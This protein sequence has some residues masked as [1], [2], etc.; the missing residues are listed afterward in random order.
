MTW[1][2]FLAAVAAVVFL[3][4]AA[5]AQDSATDGKVLGTVVNGNTTTYFM[6]A[7]QS[8]LDMQRLHAW[9]DF[10]SQHPGIARSVGHS[11]SL[12][13][14]DGYVNKHAELARLFS[15]NPGLRD[16]M[17]ANPGNYVVPRQPEGQ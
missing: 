17:I 1:K 15:D 4:P 12:L 8:D 9:S 2:V 6:A 5:M 13:S 14:N 3:A 16:A 11:P 7:N 10:A